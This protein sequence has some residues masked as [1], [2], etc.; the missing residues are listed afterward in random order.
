[1]PNLQA[2][3][4]AGE[5][6]ATQGQY[7]EAI[8][9]FDR[10]IR[11]LPRSPALLHNLASTLEAASKTAEAIERWHMALRINPEFEP[12]RVALRELAG[13]AAA[14]AIRHTQNS[15]AS[16]AATAWHAAALAA[17]SRAD[18]H[19][20]LGDALVALGRTGEGHASFERAIAADPHHGAAYI[21]LGELAMGSSSQSPA[22]RA[23]ALRWL[24]SAVAL[25]PKS[26]T[27]WLLLGAAQAEVARRRACKRRQPRAVIS[28]GPLLYIPQW[29]GTV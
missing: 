25:T 18:Y 10:A 12:S 7:A 13:G 23:S 27:A 20:S 1:M 9:A 6:L 8:H 24:R 11:M 3:V 4:D 5:A 21:G 15:D 26:S 29:Y 28:S 22:S 16:S 2:I 17:P 14:E 19:S